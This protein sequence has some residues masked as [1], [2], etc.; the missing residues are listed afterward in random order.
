VT[1]WSGRDYAEVSSLQRAMAT[2]A[3]TSLRFAQDERVLDVGCGDGFLTR[4]LAGMVPGGRAVGVDASPRM[5]ATAHAGG[6][7]APSGPWFVVA[8]ARRLPFAEYFDAVVSFNALHWVPE[9]EAALSEIASVLRS[10]GRVLIQVVCAGQRTSLETVTMTVCQSPRWA[11]WFEG[12]AAPFVH[13]DPARYG[14]LAAS[15]GLTLDDVRVTDREWD[16]GSREE[17][18]RWSS[19]GSGAWTD[20]LPAQH[21]ADFVDDQ[22]QA[23]EPIAGRPG[24]FRFTQ[25]RALLHR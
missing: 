6:Q 15:A 3:L 1:D 19:V 23:Y 21:R 20:R 14:D 9:Q 18:A 8:D 2:E 5:I 24:L 25:M 4:V 22:V 16:F 7:A 10:D 12:F 13:V 17:F 11:R